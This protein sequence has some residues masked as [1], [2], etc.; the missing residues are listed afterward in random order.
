MPI[1]SRKV[2]PL[3]CTSFFSLHGV[4]VVAQTLAHTPIYYYAIP[5]FFYLLLLTATA[6]AASWALSDREKEKDPEKDPK[7]PNCTELNPFCQRASQP[8]YIA[9]HCR[10][11]NN[12]PL[13]QILSLE[14][15]YV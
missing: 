11:W 12:P 1:L 13:F 10:F 4:F 7:N 14:P 8:W 5:A 2:L 6:T 9:S 15:K 3:Y